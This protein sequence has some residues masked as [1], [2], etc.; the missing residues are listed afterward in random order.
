MSQ[1]YQT[2]YTTGEFA[3][4]CHT[5]KETLFH[6]DRIGILKP[7]IVKENGY[8]YYLS[9]QY[10]EYDLIKVLQ[11]ARMNLKEIKAFMDERNNEKFVAILQQ[12]YQD[13]EN[14]KKRIENMQYRIQRS[15]QV[16]EYSMQMKH[17]S[18]YIEEC[19]DEH[20][21][22]MLLPEYSLSDKEMIEYVSDHLAYCWKNNLTEEI[23]LGTIV[24]KERFMRGVYT[25]NLYFTK[26]SQPTDDYHYHLKEKGTY[27]TILHKGFYDTI[28][29]SFELLLKFIDKEGYV[30]C[31]D[32]YEYEINN[33]F[34]THDAQDYLI[35]L[36]IPV[37]KQ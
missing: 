12:K 11:G 29:R 7:R 8:R 18:P 9:N 30:I 23:P 10:F 21:L 24:K 36:S 5:T 27:A 6:Y 2:Y 19:D 13:L 4:L 35:S 15:I 20:L 37:K 26:I 34:T 33:Y 3:K 31:G 16:T 14:E 28:G 1:Y 22:V 32:A 17:Q 25:E